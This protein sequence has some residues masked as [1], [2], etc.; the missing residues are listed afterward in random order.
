MTYVSPNY[1]N[2]EPNWVI[3]SNEEAIQTINKNCV[4][5]HMVGETKAFLFI[6]TNVGEQWAKQ[7]K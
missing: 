5:F 4:R 3:V 7:L 1:S 6:Q 2:V